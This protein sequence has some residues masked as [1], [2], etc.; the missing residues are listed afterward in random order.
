[1]DSV[2]YSYNINGTYKL[3]QNMQNGTISE[4]YTDDKKLKYS[5]KP[6]DILKSAKN[7]NE[8][9]YAKETNTQN[10]HYWTF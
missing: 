3:K 10:C 6:D 4:L 7:F 9:L 1:M 2:Y 8:K 5:T